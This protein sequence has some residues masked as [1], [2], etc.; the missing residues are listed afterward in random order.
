MSES[1]YIVCTKPRA[2]KKLQAILRAWHVLNVM[3]T[4]VK[5]RKVQRRTVKTDIPIF[6]GYLMARLDTEKRLNVIKTNLTTAVLPLKNARAVLRQLHQLVKAS[7]Q[8][9]EFRLVMP[10]QA[11]DA[12][13]I[14]NG[15]MMGLEGRVK[16]VEGKTLLTVDVEA[17]GGAIEVQVSPEDC[18]AA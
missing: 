16:T 10:T 9:E 12:V 1:W 6:P 4:Y 18:V 15:P 13:R 5:V 3:P 17:F 14:V 2:E 11:G 8:T 7:M